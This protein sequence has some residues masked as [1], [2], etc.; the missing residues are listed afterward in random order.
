VWCGWACPQTVFLEGVYRPIERFIEGPRERRLKAAQGP[1]TLG[2]AL[3]FVAKQLAFFVV[4][5]LIAHT[6]TALFVSPRELWLMITEG[7]AAHMEAF[8]LTSGF[9][10]I[11]VFN[12]AWFREQFCVVLC[13]YGRLQSVLHDKES[14]T[15]AYDDKRGEPR[16]HL[17]RSTAEA[18]RGDCIDC[19]KC[20]TACP[21]GIDIRLG[22]QMECI[23]CHQCI[24]A[25]DEVMRKVKKPEG[26]I[27]F[28]SVQEQA[29]EPRRVVRPRLF[30]YGA[31]VV[32]ALGTLSLSLAL[33]TPFE[34]NVLRPRGGN[35]W[36]VDGEVIRNAF[37][38]HLINK[39]PERSTFHITATA[40]VPATIFVGTPDVS[41]GSLSDTRVPVSVS[42]EE[43]A[44]THAV[45]VTLTITD[46]ASGKQK[47]QLV[48]FLA[49]IAH[50]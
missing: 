28:M 4:S 47:D 21:T 43:S 14:I 9:T 13:P 34:A 10:A 39:G 36:M 30:A 12:F 41:L 20:V 23:A 2:R 19:G 18:S 44:L 38:V 27:R 31:I 17:A 3:R 46:S 25:C 5:V 22:L 16:G 7:P 35:P 48:R 6:A 24:D 32:L 11:L 45:D 50:R 42:I 8:L 15:V 1:W 29:G 49:P 37:E 26:L 40:T 33:R